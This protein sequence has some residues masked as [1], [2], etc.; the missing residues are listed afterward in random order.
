MNQVKPVE[1]TITSYDIKRSKSG[2][3]VPIVNDIHLHSIYD[4]EKEAFNFVDRNFHL[5][6]NKSNLLI[7]GIGFGYHIIELQKLLS[8]KKL[9]KNI[10]VIDPC[11]RLF[12]DAINLKL[13]TG[14]EATYFIGEKIQ[15]LYENEH[16]IRLLLDNPSVISHPSS[17]NLFRNYFSSFL[18]FKSTQQ[19]SEG[20]KYLKNSHLMNYISKFTEANSVDE[21]IDNSILRKNSINH[22]FDYYLLAFNFMVTQGSNLQR[23]KSR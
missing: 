9:K 2:L 8:E 3:S 16:L 15:T 10:V 22:I 14:D 12:K 5:F 6:A 4:P 1:L 21:I 18:S 17:F 13:I 20:I 11:E 7:L 23:E 19:L